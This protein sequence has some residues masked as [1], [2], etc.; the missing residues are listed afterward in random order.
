[1]KLA[2]FYHE[3]DYPIDFIIIYIREAHASDGWKF[4]GSKYSFIRHHRNIS[5]RLNASKV[6][7]EMAN[8]S[9]EQR[10]SIYCDT[11]DNIT[12]NLF[13]AWPEQ[14]YVLHDQKIVYQGEE[15]PDGYSIPSVDYFLK[16]QVVVNN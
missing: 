5:E 2:S 4:D 9:I 13:R 8:I 11:M 3:L 7:I 1:M 16:K 12:N 10:V 15:G 6:M 14:L